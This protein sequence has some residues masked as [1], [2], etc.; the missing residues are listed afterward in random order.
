LEKN[1]LLCRH[2]LYGRETQVGIPEALKQRLLRYQDQSVL[3]GHPG[4]RRMYD[5]LRRYVYWPTM[6]VDVY[7]HVKQCPACAKNRLSEIRHTSTMKLFPALEPFSGLEM[8]LLGPLTT[9]RGG[10]KHVLVICDRFTKLT[11][12]IPLRDATALTVSSAF[13]DTW[14]A[15]YGIP[16]SVLTDNGPQFASV[17][18]LGILSLPGIASNDTSPYHPHTNGQVE[19]YNRTLVRQLRCY[20]A[21]QQKEWDS[22]LSL[23]TTSYNTQ[24]HASTGEIPFAFM[25]PRRL[26]TIGMERMPR[27]R[28]AEERTE[29]ASTAA[30]Q[31]VEDLQALIQAV[32]RGLGKAQSTYKRAFDARI[33]ETNN[34]VKAGD[35]VYLDAH[36]RSSKKL[37]FRTHGPYMVLQTD[38]HRFL[39]ES[40]KGLRTVSSD[41]VTGAPAPPARDGKWT[42]ALRAQALFK[43]GYQIKEGPEFVF[44]RF[45]NHSWDDDGQ[46]KVLVKWF[47]FPEQEATWQLASSLPREAIRKYCLRRRV[48]LPALTREGVF[49]SNQVRRRPLGTLVTSSHR[50]KEEHKKR[51]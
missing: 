43:V 17:Y 27:L 14:V 8:D 45:L 47:G 41:H 28:Q 20:I 4:S 34:S 15:A 9:S 2:S 25:S 21:E 49:F 16:D 24:V 51:G 3:A 37:G 38:G 31:Y 32:R 23:L 48:K 29:D 36:S 50:Q 19:R 7:K 13:I 46:L 35:W 42:R 12:A 5:T 26:Q 6:V 10:H 33:K 18:F 30:E 11:R 44:E 1:G 22:H 40:P 39:V